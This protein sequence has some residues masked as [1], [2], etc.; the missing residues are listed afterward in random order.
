MNALTLGS[1]DPLLYFN[2]DPHGDGGFQERHGGA[3]LAQQIQ[4]TVSMPVSGGNGQ[5][6]LP[7]CVFAF[8]TQDTAVDKGLQN[9]QVACFCGSVNG[10]L[11]DIGVQSF[12]APCA[13][14]VNTHCLV[15]LCALLQGPLSELCVPTEGGEVQDHP[16]LVPEWVTQVRGRVGKLNQQR[17][18]IL[19]TMSGLPST[20]RLAESHTLAHSSHANHSSLESRGS[21][22]KQ[23][24]SV[25]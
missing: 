13:I 16:F 21:Y 20:L 3:R 17:D 7:G 4:R 15:G 25:I 23:V 1:E 24:K 5:G 19:V 8:Q 6:R 9:Q 12:M 14:G 11:S 18:N 10:A 2:I 22:W